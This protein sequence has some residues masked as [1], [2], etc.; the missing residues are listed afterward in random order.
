MFPLEPAVIFKIPDSDL[1]LFTVAALTTMSSQATTEYNTLRESVLADE[2][3]QTDENLDSLEALKAFTTAAA[4]EIKGR[5]AKG[6]RL[7]TLPELA[8]TVETVEATPLVAAAIEAST[9]FSAPTIAQLAPHVPALEGEVLAAEPTVYG[10]MFAAANVDGFPADSELKDLKA[11]AKAFI[12]KTGSF[13][14]LAALGA[15][16]SGEPISYQVAYLTRDYPEEFS[17]YD[18]EEDDAVLAKVIDEFGRFGSGGLLAEVER[19]RQK[20]AESDPL[21]DGLVAAVGW[22]APSE[23]LYDTCFQGVIDGLLDV[24]EVQARRGGIRHNQGIDFTGVFGGGTGFFNLTE[25]QV[26]AGTTKTCIE[27]PCPEFVD[28]RLGVTGLCITGNILQNRGY[29]EFVALWMRAAMVASA[30]QINSLQIAAIVA[31]STAVDLSA[32]PTFLSDG[33]VASQVMAAIE[34]AIVDMKYRLRMARS[35]TLEVILPWWLLA[36]FRADFSRRNGGDYLDNMNLTDS[37]IVSWFSTRGARA[38]WVLDWQDAFAPTDLVLP[39]V[40]GGPGAATAISAFP[41]GV[42]FLVYPAGTWVRAV[43]DVITLSVIYES[44]KLV[45]NQLTQLFTETGWKMMRMCPLSRVYT[46]PIC[47]SGNTGAQREVTCA[48]V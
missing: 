35:S 21:R 37:Q 22:C 40:E 4:T 13:A 6:T 18:R 20:L 15:G 36:Q 7:A 42:K 17:V 23:T 19:N 34:L 29:P 31:G 27:I 38:Q 33:S 45:T 16:G 8:E 12:S 24:P 32:S 43:S 1:S 48:T 5:G 41:G 46:V 26:I 25:A 3:L 39:P 2:S 30:H 10:R 47:P 9:E 28:D 14:S 11:L 44:T